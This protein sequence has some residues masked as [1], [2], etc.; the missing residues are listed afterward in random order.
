MPQKSIEFILLRQ[1]A[2]YLSLPFMIID[3]DGNLVYFNEAVEHFIG[4]RFAEAG[5][6]PSIEWSTI[7]VPHDRNGHPISPESSPLFTSYRR[8]QPAHGILNIMSLKNKIWTVEVF[9]MPI[10][11]HTNDFLGFAAYFQEIRE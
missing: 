9:T 6:I 1:F 11:N 5:E 10:M 8:R 3:Q 2:T 4:V 7:F